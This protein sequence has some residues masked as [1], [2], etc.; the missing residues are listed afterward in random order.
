VA[1]VLVA[2]SSGEERSRLEAALYEAG[3]SVIIATDGEQALRST[4]GMNP[5]VVVLQSNL[6][7]IPGL[8]IYTRLF[9]TGLNLPPFL[10]LYDHAD[11][12]PDETPE[13]RV[14][15][16][17]T[18]GLTPEELAHQV[19]LL[20]LAKDMAGEF[21]DTLETMHG[22][23]TQM[24]F[25]ELLQAL[26]KHVVTGKVSF[27]V[28]PD[29]GV[30]LEDGLVVDAWWGIARGVKAFNRLAALPSGAFSL[31]LDHPEGEPTIDADLATLITEAVDERLAVDDALAE[32]PALDHRPEVKVGQSFFD[33]DFGP[34]ERQTL[35]QAQ[36]A[37]T[38]GE[39]IDTVPAPDIEV[40]QAVRRLLDEEVLNLREPADRIHIFTDS[41]ADILPADARRLG[42]TVMGVS[43]IFGSEVYKDGLD[44]QPEDFYK[45]LAEGGRLPVT[46]PVTQGEFTE[47]YRRAIASGDV[48]SIHCS[49]S[50]SRSY[51]N[52]RAAAEEGMEQFREVRRQAK[53]A[54]EPAV[55]TIDGRQ[56]SGPLGMMVILA[57][58][59]VRAGLRVR[60][61]ATRIEDMRS[62]FHTLLEVA[63]L[64]YLHSSG[65]LKQKP[66]VKDRGVRPILQVV[67]GELKVVDQDARGGRA[68][69][70]LL[71]IMT[72]LVDP[73]RPV[74][75]SL[76][77]SAAPAG[78]A[79]LRL[80]LH[81]HYRIIELMEHQIGPAVASHTGPGTV[82][83][84]LFQPTD[85][86]LKLLR[87]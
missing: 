16:A 50:L 84:G 61:V 2:H 21:G 80:L 29:A 17:A 34:V 36:K 73:S 37:T 1:S 43:I 58:R 78:A 60:E 23:L 31:T 59:M 48:L 57:T 4:A 18:D 22:D 81:R 10:I 83:A 54:A 56:A 41:T 46:N 47:A 13:G 69:V 25:S 40:L 11:S 72:G 66:V 26:Q 76:V 85:E 67:D 9:K 63:S 8:E 52:A 15:F 75:A 42:I 32:L 62:R 44:L 7:G 55:L 39:L 74:F 35:G 45:R 28:N 68:H 14:Y 87:V 64:D 65:E 82:G 51:E 49:A 12:F 30:W 33:L 38:F 71:E 70:R 5:S 19:R 24:P 27:K 79:Q 86:E 6:V 3:Y 20:L 53:I 77:H